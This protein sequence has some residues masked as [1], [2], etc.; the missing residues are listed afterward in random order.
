ERRA[1]A[2]VERLQEYFECIG[3]ACGDRPRGKAMQNVAAAV[4][5]AVVDGDDLFRKRDALHSPDSFF[6]RGRLV[7]DGQHD[8]ELH[9]SNS[10]FFSS[11]INAERLGSL[12]TAS[13]TLF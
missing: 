12:L 13:L 2:L 9:C 1:F 4:R 8:G 6:E 3:S 5:R 10:R 11:R 7:V